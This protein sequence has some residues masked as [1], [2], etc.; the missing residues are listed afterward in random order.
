MAEFRKIKVGVFG[1]GRGRVFMNHFNEPIGLELVAVCD[2]NPTKVE[3]AKKSIKNLDIVTFYEDFDEFLKHPD[4]EAVVLANY[5]NEHAPYAIKALKAGKHVLSE[6]CACSTLKE[7]VELCEAVEESGKIY[8]IAENYPY[9]AFNQEMR[10]L[11]HTGEIGEVMYAEGEYNHPVSPSDTNFRQTYVYFDNH[12]RNFTPGTYYVT[13]SLGP[14][15]RATGATPKKVSVFE[16]LAQYDEQAKA[17]LGNRP[18]A[19]ITTQNDDGSIFRFTGC[20][21]FG[22]QHNAYRV[23]GTRGQIENMR[24]DI[25]EI[26]LRY[27]SWNVPEGMETINRYIPEWTD[28]DKDL[29]EKSGH[30]GSDFVTLRMFFNCV[31]E[32][33][34][35][36]RPFDVYSAVSMSS[37]AIL[38]HRSMLNG[39]QR[40]EIPDFTK[41]EQREKY[42]NDNLTPYYGADGSKP[43]VPV[44]SKID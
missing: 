27:N 36:E 26:L 31:R 20:S 9:T 35:P 3:V 41:E 37:V 34:Q 42:E 30:G 40:I 22:G 16:C 15:M 29:I 32:G 7:G 11:Y 10:R 2:N 8:M 13:H 24:S 21:K 1:A 14:L 17:D 25:T 23:C 39:G 38:G 28:K 4:M 19:I 44:T 12:W 6:C 18:T 5:F 33:K 43:T